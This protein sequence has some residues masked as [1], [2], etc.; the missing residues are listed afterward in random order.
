[1]P[2]ESFAEAALLGVGD[3]TLFPVLDSVTYLDH[4]AVAPL[5]A[6]AASA[7]R[8]YIEAWERFGSQAWGYE[9]PA[10]VRRL[11]AEIT[12]AASDEELAVVPNTSTGLAT[13]ARGLQMRRGDVVVVP[14]L[15]FPANRF[16]W[17]E[18][19]QDGVEVVVV[20]ADE[21]LIIQDDRLI[22]AM[23]TAFRP[24]ATNVLAV[25]HVQF[26]TGQRH[27]VARLA[28]AAHERGGLIV[29]DA[30]QS[31]GQM[32]LDAERSGIDFAAADGHKWMLGPEGAGILYCRRKH[33]ERLRP[34]IIGWL[35]MMDA[36]AF[37]A[38]HMV[39]RRD[40]RRFEPGCWNL[41]GLMGLAASLELLLRV[42]VEAIEARVSHLAG[43]LREGLRGSGFELVELPAGASS[44]I[45][46]AWPRP[47]DVRPDQV[48]K[49]L[50]ERG[51]RLALRRGLFR[52]SPHF[53]NT[54]EH[55][56]QAIEGLSECG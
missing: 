15:E 2:E 23:R 27:D 10:K 38:D 7:M 49:R 34:A 6:P 17:E 50:E 45:V 4:A 14:Q 35:N 51:V 42:G 47:T 11:G 56:R 25:S 24:R 12:G 19:E 32:P 18:L 40:A 36:A 54:D 53:Y 16:V 13:I 48:I 37:S 26:S 21:H 3:S 33:L 52:I 43:R 1:V 55:M 8:R 44:G 41:G 20:P 5:P 28:E 46:A 9:V 30:I 39:L 31:I 22:D 29:V